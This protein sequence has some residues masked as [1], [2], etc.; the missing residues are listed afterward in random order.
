MTMDRKPRNP[1]SSQQRPQRAAN[2]FGEGN[3]RAVA[4]DIA[5]K[6]FRGE[7]RFEHVWK[8]H[9]GLLLLTSRDRALAVHL[10]SGVLRQYR[11]LDAQ[12][13]LLTSGKSDGLNDAVQ[14]IMRFGLFQVLDCDR[15]PAHAA[16]STAVDATKKVAHQ[17]IAG[18]MNAV[19]RRAAREKESPPAPSELAAAAQPTWG[20]RFSMQDWMADLLLERFG[21]DA[22]ERIARWANSPP[23]YYLRLSQAGA[24]VQRVDELLKEMRL[25]PS[26]PYRD[27][28][29]YLAIE[30][31][32]LVSDSP[33]FKEPLGW[34]Q[35]PG[36][37]FVV[38]LLGLNT[39]DSVIDLFAAPGGKTLAISEIVG[40]SGQ[41][42]AVD[43]SAERLKRLLENKVR[44]SA[45]NILPIEADI[46][47]L[48]DRVAPH[49]LAD[50]PCSALGTLPKNPE[51]RWTKSPEDLARLARSQ[52]IWLNLAA[53]HVSEGGVL[54]Y[55][56]CTI[57]RQE[58]EEVVQGFLAANAGFA[59]ESAA[60]YVP[61]RHVTPEGYL[62]TNPPQDGLDG[63]FG[64]RLRRRS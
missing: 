53:T 52:R 56:T 30:T 20:E 38:A 8:S 3:A 28:P 22:A 46:A 34:V 51:V 60:S 42:L 10:A 33:L 47:S 43:K 14:W 39:G 11:R 19:L 1:R 35:N 13:R 24:G 49:I 18:L 32:A 6:A 2:P 64:A 27:L 36:A 21:R 48:G 45:E 62:A 58:N 57:S 37:G 12:A 26:R 55:S 5:T 54:V 9:P 63:V 4:Y 40:P 41:V 25:T 61:A 17:G 23:H 50:V 59:L 29:E 31:A 15:I 7:E 44:F 16:V